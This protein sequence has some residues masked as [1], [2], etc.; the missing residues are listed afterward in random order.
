MTEQHPPGSLERLADIVARLQEHHDPDKD[1]LDP[2]DRDWPYEWQGRFLRALQVMQHPHVPTAYRLAGVSKARLYQVK[3]SDKDFAAAMQQVLDD[4]RGEAR[5]RYDELLWNWASDGV[6]VRTRKTTTKR[7]IDASGTLIEEVTDT[8]I[9]EGSERSAAV[10]I[11]YGKAHFPEKYRWSER[12]EATGPE[13]GPIEFT[14][15][16]SID[17]RIAQLHAELSAK[18]GDEPVPTE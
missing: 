8:T 10:A 3:A 17:D 2:V 18:A 4:A 12:V 5:Q 6:P 14:T 16:A 15:I 11:F 9:T 1:D 7:K 13:G